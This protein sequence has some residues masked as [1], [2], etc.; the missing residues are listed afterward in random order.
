MSNL[1]P[2]NLIFPAEHDRFGIDFFQILLNPSLELG[3]GMHPDAPQKG[4]RHL[5][6]EDLNEIEPRAVC[7]RKNKLKAVG[8]RGPV[9]LSFFRTMRGVIVD[10]QADLPV[11]RIGG[12]Q[13]LEQLDEFSAA[14]TPA[15]NPDDLPRV[16]IDAAQQAQRPVT[17]IF[18]VPSPGAPLTWLGRL[19]CSDVFQGLYARLFV[20]AD[21]AHLS[22]VLFLGARLVDLHH[23]FVNQQNLG[24]FPLKFWIALLQKLTHLVGVVPVQNPVHPTSSHAPQFPDNPPP[25][26]AG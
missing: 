14:V 18:V 16:Q 13:A 6:E 23:F 12:V 17:D 4:T 25:G 7:R 9:R 26:R 8:T 10:H 21:G 24:F 19:I 11:G 5:A 2:L 1:R 22:L 3:Q 15:H 20:H